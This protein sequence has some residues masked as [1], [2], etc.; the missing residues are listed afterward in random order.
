[1]TRIIKKIIPR[2]NP[3]DTELSDAEA[4]GI[5]VSLNVQLSEESFHVNPL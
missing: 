4:T 5:T 2:I 1:M 3:T